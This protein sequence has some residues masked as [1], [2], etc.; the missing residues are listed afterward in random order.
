MPNTFDTLMALV[1]LIL[2][3]DYVVNAFRT[4]LEH[5]CRLCFALFTLH[6]LLAFTFPICY[7][8]TEWAVV[9]GVVWC[10]E[11]LK[12]LDKR[13]FLFDLLLFLP[14]N[15]IKH[16]FS[17]VLFVVAVNALGVYIVS[18]EYLIHI[19]PALAATPYSYFDRSVCTTRLS[20]MAVV[21][22]FHHA[23]LST[24]FGLH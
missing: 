20:D 1:I 17:N 4:S 9:L 11:L 7:F 10:L 12:L 3:R 23:L 15:L 24:V 13:C 22:C 21:E 19:L 6:S 5:Q 2:K 18:N 16:H 8:K 14:P